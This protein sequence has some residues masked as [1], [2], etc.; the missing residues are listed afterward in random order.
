LIRLRNPWGHGEW[1]LKWSE[2]VQECNKLL[3]HMPYIEN[4]YEKETERCI[5]LGIEPP[6]P[7]EYGQEDG[8]F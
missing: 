6:E 5:K 4:Y 1:K 3:E 7:Y 8:T 2:N